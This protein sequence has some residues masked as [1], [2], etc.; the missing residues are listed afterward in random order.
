MG[1]LKKEGPS[2]SIVDALMLTLPT[3]GVCDDPQGFGRSGEEYPAKK[4]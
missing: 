3:G 4:I 1:A 2:L